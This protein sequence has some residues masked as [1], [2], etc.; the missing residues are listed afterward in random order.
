MTR[1][2]SN[3]LRK[4][5]VRAVLGGESCRSVASRFGVSVS[6]VV[7]WAQRYRSDRL[8]GA[9]PDG[10]APQTSA[11]AA[12]NV[13]LG[14][15][16]ANAP[17]DAA[18]VKGRTRRARGPCLTQCCMAVSAARGAAIQKKR[19]SLLSKPV[20]TSPA[21]GGAGDHGRPT[22]IH[23]VWSSSTRPGSRPAWPRFADGPKG[24]RLRGFAPHGHWQTLTFL[25]ALRC[26]QLT[27]PC[28]FDGPINGECFRAY[29]EQQLAPV[30]GYR[31][32]AR[33]D[34]LRRL[35]PRYRPARHPILRRP[36]A[37]KA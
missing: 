36:P 7:K 11:R 33:R 3:D 34:R 8:G 32:D 16:R 12:S 4:R 19:C 9:G 5:V 35:E 31:Y 24:H 21:G 29:V 10:W 2:L 22:S 18:R 26:D 17:A 13:H 6:S 15:D 25:G 37:A 14:T 23:G 20:P 27:A 28:V 30:H 1:P